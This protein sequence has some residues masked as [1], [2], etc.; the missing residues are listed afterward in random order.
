MRAGTRAGTGLA[1][2]LRRALKTVLLS[3][4]LGVTLLVVPDP[5][6]SPAETALIKIER[7]DGVDLSP[8]VIWIMAIG[9]DARPGEEM[10]RSRGDALQL[11]GINTQTGAAATIGIPRDSYVDIP[12]YGSNKINAALTFGGPAVMASSVEG[13]VGIEPDY[14]MVAGFVGMERMVNGIGGITV[15][16]PISFSDDSLKPAGFAAGK[17]RLR[18]YDAMAFSRIRHNLIGGDFDRSANQQRTLMGILK[19]IRD[20]ADRPG[21]I[22]AGVTTVLKNMDTNASPGELFQIAQAIAQVDPKQVTRCVLRGGLGSAGGASV[23]FPDLAMAKG[24]GD[25]ARRDASIEHC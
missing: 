20:R 24:L 11:V 10:T 13:L 21:F 3:S 12:G 15:N 25:Q 7:A 22:Q 4:V 19:R 9:S 18:G 17:I 8:D 14:V 5:S 1:R 2:M 23:V 6:V 16:N